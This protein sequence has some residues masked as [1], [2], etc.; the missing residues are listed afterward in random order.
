M[1]TGTLRTVSL[2]LATGAL[3]LAGVV[4]TA[5]SAH[6]TTTWNATDTQADVV[7]AWAHGSL[8]VEGNETLSVD[9]TIKDTKADGASARAYIRW[10]YATGGFSGS[11]V[12]TVSGGNGSTKSAT[13][14]NPRIELDSY[15][16]FEIKEC[17]VD[18]GWETECGGWDVP[19]PMNSGW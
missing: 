7:G 14:R 18:N 10:R 3:A 17:L 16:P 9:M 12:L 13:Y 1:T 6:A 15:Q 8:D 5:T 4:G 2:A 11:A 19:Y